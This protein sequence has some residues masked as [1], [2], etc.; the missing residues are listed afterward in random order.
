MG[1]FSVLT[2]PHLPPPDS[3]LP[4]PGTRF[5]ADPGVELS[6][7]F[8][9]RRIRAPV[10]VD[11]PQRELGHPPPLG[12]VRGAR[13]AARGGSMSFNGTTRNRWSRSVSTV[14]S[15]KE[16]LCGTA[17]ALTTL[18]GPAPLTSTAT[19]GTSPWGS[20]AFGMPW[21]C[22]GCANPGRPASSRLPRRP[23]PFLRCRQ[24][25]VHCTGRQ[26]AQMPVIPGSVCQARH[27]GR[28][29]DWSLS[30]LRWDRGKKAPSSKLQPP[31]KFQRPKL[32]TPGF[33]SNR[34]GKRGLGR[35]DPAVSES[36]TSL[37]RINTLQGSAQAAAAFSAPWR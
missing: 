19:P 28:I 16:S 36:V 25:Q 13:V 22:T 7:G 35:L 34:P 3:R 9:T 20:D 27:S 37:E 29:L 12:R 2:G 17:G 18:A 21:F 6:N 33:R 23:S 30:Q 31:K 15:G 11:G 10:E 1:V 32:P 4:K 8:W 26:D 24:G 14:Y 5:L